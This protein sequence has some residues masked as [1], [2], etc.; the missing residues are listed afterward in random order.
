MT[1]RKFISTLLA[2]VLATSVG[3]AMAAPVVVSSYDMVN[4]YTGSYQ[5]WDDTYSGSGSKTTD[6]A[7]LSG[8][9]GDLTDGIK[10]TANW[11]VT[12]APAG[13]GPYVGWLNINPVIHFHFGGP[14]TINTISFNVDD[15]NGYG[16]VSTP[17]SVV[18]GGVTYG[19]TD[20]AGSAPFQFDVSGLSLNVSDLDITINR[21]NAW[22]FVSEIAFAGSDGGSVPEPGSLALLGL[23]LAGLALRKRTSR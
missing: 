17:L 9:K 1:T 7:P 15:A 2:A 23:G 8:G 16:G 21:R 6:G 3:A 5:Y 12:E 14:V 10:A 22:V 18:I 4:G 20:P 11:Y 19:L 13:A